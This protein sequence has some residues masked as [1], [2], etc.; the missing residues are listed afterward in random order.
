M[1]K[2]EFKLSMPHRASWNGGWSGA[3]KNY[4]ITKNIKDKTVIILGFDKT[5]TKCWYYSFGDGWTACVTGRIIP[6]GER[7]K[8][9]DGFCGYNWMVDEIVWYNEI[10]GRK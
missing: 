6:K 9:S 1:Y 7:V 10:R 4:T 3:E 2:I 8:K 5:D